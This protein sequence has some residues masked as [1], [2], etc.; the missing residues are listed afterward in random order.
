MY[1]PLGPGC[2]LTLHLLPRPEEMLQEAGQLKDLQGRRSF[3]SSLYSFESRVADPG[4]VEPEPTEKLDPDTDPS[5]KK[6]RI[7]I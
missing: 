4:G 1:A 6:H 3:R 2:L 7:G 5:V